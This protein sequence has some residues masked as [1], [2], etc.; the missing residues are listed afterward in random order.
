M[1]LVEVP[2][3]VLSLES[4]SSVFVSCISRDGGQGLSGEDISLKRCGTSYKV[5]KQ[6]FV[7][8]AREVVRHF[9]R[10]QLAREL[11]RASRFM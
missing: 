6:W 3:S 9:T 5:G 11:G 1:D 7:R 10:L 8:R 2:F 4:H